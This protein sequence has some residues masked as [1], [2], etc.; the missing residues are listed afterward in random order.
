MAQ[1]DGAIAE[2][3]LRWRPVGWTAADLAALEIVLAVVQ[4]WVAAARP[5]S[6]RVAGKWMQ[7]ISLL[8]IWAYRATG[9][10]DPEVVFH[11]RN[12]EVWAMDENKHRSD[13]WK[14]AAR[15]AG[16]RVGRAVYPAGW[17]PEPIISS[18]AP[19]VAAYTADEQKAYRVEASERGRSNWPVRLWVWAAAFGGGLNAPEIGLAGPG[20]L[21]DLGG[22]RVAVDVAGRNPRL[23]PIREI[24][25]DAVLEAARACAGQARF[26]ES[27]RD[28]AASKV[29]E[30]LVVGGLG[31]IS[32][33]RCRATWLTAHLV[34]GTPLAALRAIAGPV[35][36]RTL[37][38]LMGAAAG[39]L[40]AEEAA[41]LGLSA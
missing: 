19:V 1:L 35:S 31:Q 28:S 36:A 33:S 6:P 14:Q 39:T 11:P 32:L 24:C 23:V 38:S 12:V 21:V 30:R 15:S 8:A 9:S 26:I 40:T 2:A 3:L 27:D 4:G 10:L 37:N 20:G 29:A 22:G 25:T 16:R 18:K 13:T 17:P 41:A 7:L 5:A 34:G